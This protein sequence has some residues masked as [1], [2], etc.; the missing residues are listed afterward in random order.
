MH[1]QVS[2]SPHADHAAEPCRASCGVA[3]MSLEARLHASACVVVAREISSHA[4]ATENSFFDDGCEF[5]DKVFFLDLISI[6]QK[7]KMTT[8]PTSTTQYKLA[9]ESKHVLRSKCGAFERT[10]SACR[11]S[12]T[13]PA[14]KRWVIH[15]SNSQ[16]WINRV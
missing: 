13:S 8:G 14:K 4:L 11:I 12:R 9:G 10:A 6:F 7:K 16:N 5:I 15:D 2:N 3:I 1:A